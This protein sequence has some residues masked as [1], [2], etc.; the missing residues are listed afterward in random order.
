MV[1]KFSH[2]LHIL[3]SALNT[4]AAF[5]K[6]EKLQYNLLCT[7]YCVP[8][9]HVPDQAEIQVDQGEVLNKA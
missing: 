3:S 9:R 4:G 2:D 8:L 1:P 5:Y 6:Y 7:L